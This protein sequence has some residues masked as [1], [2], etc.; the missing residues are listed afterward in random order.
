[1][2]I[3]IETLIQWLGPG[4][5]A[6][7]IIIGIYAL[8]LYRASIEEQKDENV[9]RRRQIQLQECQLNFLAREGY[10]VSVPATKL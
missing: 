3:P 2:D 6:A 5:M 7:I 1:M 4:P 10:D 8:K 9:L